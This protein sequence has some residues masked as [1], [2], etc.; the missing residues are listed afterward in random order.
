MDIVWH[1]PFHLNG[2]TKFELLSG[3]EILSK[4]EPLDEGGATNDKKLVINKMKLI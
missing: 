3:E 1:N 2:P 4:L